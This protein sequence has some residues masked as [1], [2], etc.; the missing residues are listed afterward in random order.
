MS[1]YEVKPVSQ[2]WNP[3][4]GV[5]FEFVIAAIC[6]PRQPKIHP[7]DRRQVYFDTIADDFPVGHPLARSPD[8]TIATCFTIR[9]HIREALRR[10]NFVTG[11]GDEKNVKVWEVVEDLS[12]RVPKGEEYQ[13]FAIEVRTPAFTYSSNALLEVRLVCSLLQSQFRI[14]VNQSCGLHVHIGNRTGDG[15]PLPHLRRICAFLHAFEPQLDTVH[16]PHRLNNT[17]CDSFRWGTNY[18]ASFRNDGQPPPSLAEATE[19]WLHGSPDTSALVAD[20]ACT[21]G[22]AALAYCL[23]RASEYGPTR[24]TVE[25]RQHEATLEAGA[26]TMWIKTLIGITTWL[27]HASDCEVQALLSIAEHEKWAAQGKKGGLHDAEMMQWYGP[28]FADKEFTFIGLLARLQLWEAAEY[29]DGKLYC[30]AWL[31][32]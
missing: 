5:E 17:Y 7:D 16:P 22:N 11:D 6:D 30:H 27:R 31:E 4:F 10:G 28:A 14:K 13:Y 12:I 32:N 9:R 26:V 29:Y 19:Y 24:A 21:I 18:A 3:S 23:E 1:R 20:A 25:F 15:F 8:K 2:E